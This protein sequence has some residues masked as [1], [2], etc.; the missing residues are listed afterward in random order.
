MRF[1]SA[2]QGGQ[3]EQ[4]EDQ[5]YNSS[6]MLLN[7][8]ATESKSLVANATT[9]VMSRSTLINAWVSGMFNRTSSGELVGQ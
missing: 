6:M 7:M 8:S 2:L 1:Q 5:G 9:M 3:G 4:G